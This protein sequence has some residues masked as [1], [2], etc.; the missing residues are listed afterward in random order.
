M[1]RDAVSACAPSPGPPRAQDLRRPEARRPGRRVPTG[2]D[3]ERR[4]LP[5][6]ATRAAHRRSCSLRIADITWVRD[7]LA[8]TRFVQYQI[9]ALSGTQHRVRPVEPRGSSRRLSASAVSLSRGSTFIASELPDPPRAFY[10]LPRFAQRAVIDDRGSAYEAHHV[11]NIN[12]VTRNPD[13]PVDT[14]PAKSFRRRKKFT[15]LVVS[16]LQCESF[17]SI[18][19]GER[20]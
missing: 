6:A 8:G 3:G 15:R 18:T 4:V 11:A 13:S 5:Q 14:N 2:L 10:V 9:H 12:P 7:H 20:G 19:V 17:M 1:R 16:C